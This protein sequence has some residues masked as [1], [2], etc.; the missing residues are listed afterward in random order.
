MLMGVSL[1]FTHFST[2]ISLHTFTFKLCYFSTKL[3]KI[4]KTQT[5]VYNLVQ[6][7]KAHTNRAK[8]VLFSYQLI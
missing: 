5:F 6:Q 4:S 3:I 7:T 1:F 2:L 8:Y